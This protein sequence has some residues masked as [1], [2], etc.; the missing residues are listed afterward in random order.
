MQIVH[1]SDLHIGARPYN[2]NI[3][4]EDIKE[5]FNQSVEMIKKERPDLF[6]ISG[7][8]FDSPKPDNDSL[9]FVI[10]K[11]KE[12]TNL[13][14]PII[15]AHGEHDTPGR[16]ETTILQVI[17]SA[18]DKVYAPLYEIRSDKSTSKEKTYEEIVENTKVSINKLNVFVYPFKKL[19]L[20]LRRQLAKELLPYYNEAIKRLGGKTVF[21]AHFSVEPIFVHDALV[22]VNELPEAS[23]IAMGHIHRRWINKEGKYYAYP[24]SLYPIESNEARFSTKR[25]PL[26]ID[27]STDVPSIQEI[28]IQVR[29]NVVK[30]LEIT[31]EK[32]IYNKIKSIVDI[33]KKTLEKN[34][35]NPLIYLKIGIPKNIVSKIVLQNVEKVKNEEN[36]VII[37]LLE[38][39][40]KDLGE[41]PYSVK[42]LS[43]SL[44]DPVNIMVNEFKIKE[45]TAKL[46]IELRDAAFEKNEERI[47]ELLTK[48]SESSIE[49]LKKV[50]A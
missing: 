23:Y 46:L 22:S 9:K 35:K 21:V 32:E 43:K 26:L 29:K 50:L 11:F 47:N 17:S 48:L 33:E 19:N 41:G 2:E 28:D 7:D 4:Y 3:I 42:S 8:L 18:V 40:N 34:N 27:L 30:E 38:R 10:Q 36:L 49:E 45:S 12:L 6:I 15:L 44:L 13:G 16:R 25:G 14:I 24:G 1:M 37:P 39:I 20:D 5:A 31:N